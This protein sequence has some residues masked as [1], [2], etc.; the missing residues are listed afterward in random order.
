MLPVG[1][2]IV[3]GLI[4]FSIAWLVYI[5]LYKTEKRAYSGRHWPDYTIF[6]IMLLVLTLFGG[7]L[8]HGTNPWD[9]YSNQRV[10]DP[11]EVEIHKSSDKLFISYGAHEVISD[12]IFYYK[13]VEDTEKVD[14]VFEE[15]RNGFN[16]FIGY[17]LYLRRDKVF[18]E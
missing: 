10:L 12:E 7:L 6:P 2:Y 18:D 16:V 11:S 14:I 4:S 13:N 3:A 5:R 8:S 15:E 17:D 9:Y 1:T